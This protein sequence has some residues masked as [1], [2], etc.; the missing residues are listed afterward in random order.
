MPPPLLL[1]G[2]AIRV[3][4]VRVRGE[5]LP[6][7]VRVAGVV[8]PLVTYV[9][10]FRNRVVVPYEVRVLPP[11]S[12]EARVLLTAHAASLSAW[13]FVL[14]PPRELLRVL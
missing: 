1:L 12:D 11:V 5:P 9:E 13:K 14:T 2:V 10:L 4:V 6:E 7:S 8:L 3:P